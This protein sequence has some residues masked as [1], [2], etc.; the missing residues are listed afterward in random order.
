MTQ[1]D[2]IALDQFR[3]NIYLLC[4]EKLTVRQLFLL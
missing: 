1:C 3:L 4:P 2:R